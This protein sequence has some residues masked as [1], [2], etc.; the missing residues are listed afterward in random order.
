LDP[1]KQAGEIAFHQRNLICDIRKHSH[2]FV[3]QLMERLR[4]VFLAPR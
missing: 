4:R 2:S 1:S 3:Q